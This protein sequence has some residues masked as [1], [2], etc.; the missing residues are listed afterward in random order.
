MNAGDGLQTRV[1]GYAASALRW[2]EPRRL[3]YNAALAAVV[4]THF[5][6][7]LPESGDKLSFELLLTLFFFAVLAN[8]AYCAAYLA[9]LFVQLSGLDE[10]WRRGRWAVWTIGTA[11]AA[12]LTHFFSQ[13]FFRGH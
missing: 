13:G 10:A 7:D 1:G 3:W 4:A 9:D 8:V 5:V 6:I 11:F 12:T 2:W